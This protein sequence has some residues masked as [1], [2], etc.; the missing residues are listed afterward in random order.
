MGG[1]ISLL[2]VN[3]IIAQV[4]VVAFLVIAARSRTRRPAIWCAAGFAVASLSAVFE[5]VLPFTP[6][7]KL[8]AVGAFASVLAGLLLIRFALGLFY[9]VPAKLLHLAIFFTAGVALDVIIYELPRGT[10]QHA[11]FYQMPFCLVQAWSAATVL[12]SERRS[13]ADKILFCLLS[14]SAIYYLVKIHAAMAAGSGSTAADY[15]TSTFALISQALGAMLIVAAGVAMLGVMVKEIIDD[16]HARSELDPLS[17]LYNRRGFMERVAPFLPANHDDGPGT[18]IL[19]DLDRFKLVNDTYGHH[20]GDEVIRQFGRVLLDLMPGQAVAGRLGGEEFAVFLPR[21][22]LAD[23]R[24][25]AH[26]MRAALASRG[27]EG[28]PETVAVTA[29]FGVAAIAAEE[30][31][32]MAM[33]RA[34]K[35]LYAAKAAGRNRVECAEPSMHLVKELYRPLR[36]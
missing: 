13:Q 8:F 20:A 15:L 5:T 10:L 4:F 3:F 24:V 12:R 11:F 18:L 21:V 2:A 29:S 28:L 32:E 6:V 19:A 25:L 35:A 7:P 17:G 27:I 36:V 16:A 9:R 30:P 14:L 26:G 22:S 34:D 31:L 1:A 33:R 23:A